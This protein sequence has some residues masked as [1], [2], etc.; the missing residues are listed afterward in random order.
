MQ[1]IYIIE[2]EN[3]YRMHEMFHLIKIQKDNIT[4]MLNSRKHTFTVATAVTNENVTSAF[5]M[6]TLEWRHVDLDLK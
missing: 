1:N 5:L 6:F 4:K 3:E 2:R